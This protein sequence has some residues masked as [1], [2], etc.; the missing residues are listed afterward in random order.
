MQDK[1]SVEETISD[2]EMQFTEAAKLISP[3]LSSYGSSTELHS[4]PDS[5]VH[6]DSSPEEVM[7]GRAGRDELSTSLSFFARY[8]QKLRRWKEKFFQPRSRI[9]RVWQKWMFFWTLWNVFSIPYRAVFYT[10]SPTAFTICS[11]LDIIGDIFFAVD[12]ITY[13]FLPYLSEGMMVKHPGK[14]KKQYLRHWF[15][16]DLLAVLPFDYFYWGHYRIHTILR[17]NRVIKVARAPGYWHEWERYA[18]HPSF[19]RLLKLLSR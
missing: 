15:V 5:S 2:S 13:F 11:I 10:N 4:F 16:V 8:T 17:I 3:K 9:R 19:T 7:Q 1:H 14:I 18:S 6:G 12:V